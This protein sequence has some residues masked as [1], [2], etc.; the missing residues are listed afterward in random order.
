MTCLLQK[1]NFDELTTIVLSFNI[2][3]LKFDNLLLDVRI[4]VDYRIKISI[5][6]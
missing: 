1:I 5:I 3:L 6:Y 2:Q 4:N